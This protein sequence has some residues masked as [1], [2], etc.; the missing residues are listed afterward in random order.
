MASSFIVSVDHESKYGLGPLLQD[1][2]QRNDQDWGL[3]RRLNRESILV[4]GSLSVSKAAWLRASLSGWLLLFSSFLHGPLNRATTFSTANQGASREKSQ[5]YVDEP[6]GEI[7]S[8][9]CLLSVG[10]ETLDQLTL[11]GKE[12]HKH[13]NPES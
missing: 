8:P 13:V 5:S 10:Q 9:L 6:P 4:I 2:S 11:K 1:L 7:P 3:I 12:L